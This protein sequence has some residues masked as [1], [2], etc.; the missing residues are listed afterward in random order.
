MKEVICIDSAN[1]DNRLESLRKYTIAEEKDGNCRLF[2]NHI[3]WDSSRFVKVD[4]LSNF[5]TDDLLKELFRR[6]K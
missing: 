6:I 1:S 5:S 2:S 3:W 4:I